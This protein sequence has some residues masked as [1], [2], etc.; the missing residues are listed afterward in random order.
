VTPLP[1]LEPYPAAAGIV[2][3]ATMEERVATSLHLNWVAGVRD[4]AQRAL[5][6]AG[7]AKTACEAGQLQTRVPGNPPP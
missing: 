5:E 3:P 7:L 1:V 4:V 2:Q 6:R